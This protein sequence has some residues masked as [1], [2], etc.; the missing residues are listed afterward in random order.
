MQLRTFLASYI[1]YNSLI[2]AMQNYPV[3]YQ[4]TKEIAP[5]N[6]PKR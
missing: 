2:K 4:L 5:K 3:V 1:T 6:T